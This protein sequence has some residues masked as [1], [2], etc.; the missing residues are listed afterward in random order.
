MDD[1]TRFTWLYPF[2]YKS[3]A[4][5][6]F[7]K[8]KVFVENQFNSS[9]KIFKTNNGWEYDKNEFQF[10]LSTHGIHHQKSCPH[11]SPQNGVAERK[12]RHIVET[13][14][15]LLSTASL[16]PHFWAH[17][18]TTAVYLINRMPSVT[19][20]H[21]SPFELLY[22][23]LPDYS[24]LKIFGCTAYPFLRPYNKNKL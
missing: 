13:G 19:T 22:G 24:N 14:L 16:P 8:F 1:F 15:T 2:I 18:F 6:I 23:H 10:L 3:E 4:Y 7:C 21:K 5:S 17:A 12:H 11:T 20:T 9:I